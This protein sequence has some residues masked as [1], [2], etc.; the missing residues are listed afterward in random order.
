M[1]W[2]FSFAHEI[3]GRWILH[4]YGYETELM[5]SNGVKIQSL[6]NASFCTDKTIT[7]RTR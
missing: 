1:Q 6:H 5:I 7:K 3:H 4:E 2:T